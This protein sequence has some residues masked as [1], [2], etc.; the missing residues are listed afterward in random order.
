MNNDKLYQGA[1]N[2][3]RKAA[4]SAKNGTLKYKGDTYTFTFSQKWWAYHI[5]DQAG[6]TIVW[7]NTKKITEAKQWLKNYLEN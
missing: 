6:N 1:L 5:V 3:A 2:K 4:K 7:L